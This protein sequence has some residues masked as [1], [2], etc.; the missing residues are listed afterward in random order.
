MEG[1][2]AV[3]RNMGPARVMTLAL[4]S[5]LMLGFFFV[6]LSRVNA[7]N[8]ALLFAQLDPKDAGAIIARLDTM[9]VP[10]QVRA[11][12]IYVPEDRVGQLRLQM[13]GEGIIGSNVKGYEVFDQSSSFGTT[14]LV[15]NI[16]ARRALEGELAR[17]ISSLPMVKAARVHLVMP[18]RH[19]FAR[20]ETEPSASI[21]LN[22]GDRVLSPE[23]IQSI[24]HLVAAA[25]PKLS[26]NKVTVIDNRGNVLASGKGDDSLAGNMGVVNK[27]RHDLESGLESHLHKMLERVVGVGKA[28]V[29][30][31]A[32]VNFDR[33]EENSESYDPDQQVVRSEQRSE[34]TSTA[35]ERNNTPPVGLAAN[36]PGQNP[37]GTSVGNSQQQIRSEETINYE[38]GRTVRRQIKEGGTVRRLSVAILVEGRYQKVDGQDTYVPYSAEELRKFEAL[39]K[40]AIGFDESR[41]DVVEIIDMP[42]S[43]LP[44][45]PPYEEPLFSRGELMKLAEYGLLFLGLLL[46]LLFVVRPIL[47][48]AQQHM[49]TQQEIAMR[50]A[51]LTVEDE[52]K[53]ED[54][55]ETMVNLSQVRGRVKESSIKKVAEI[56]E[57]SPEE[58][59][60]VIRQWMTP[61]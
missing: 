40:S 26:P 60:A 31:T 28:N 54:D 34:E 8:Y 3:L 12:N 1:L 57:Q 50:E 15:Q 49:R 19:L 23:Q 2:V 7:P 45:E 44:E 36:V 58:S 37:Q 14:S 48:Q 6:I 20:D 43:P 53:D 38:I 33:I 16:N 4:T 10:Y 21:T 25:V 30:V 29:K 51:G 13:A 61:E 52:P 5:L 24:T 27:F 9:S 46:I 47:R 17:T 11:D 41:G 55:T 39:V 59:V 18:K 56:I 42:F 32:E 35:Q 22:L